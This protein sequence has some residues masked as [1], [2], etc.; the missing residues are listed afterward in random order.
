[1]TRQTFVFNSHSNHLE[2]QEK[3]SDN[4]SL[5][6]EV[7]AQ[8]KTTIFTLHLVVNIQKWTLTLFIHHSNQQEPGYNTARFFGSKRNKPS[9]VHLRDKQQR[10]N[11]KGHN[12]KNSNNHIIVNIM[13]QPQFQPL[14]FVPHS[15]MDHISKSGIILNEKII[16]TLM[17]MYTFYN[18]LL[19]FSINLHSVLKGSKSEDISK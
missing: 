3:M 17:E 9:N 6:Q 4:K 5:H 12:A 16:L 18:A 11:H 2:F 15:Q 8:T 19:N 13:K 14:D 10:T 1:M 7:K